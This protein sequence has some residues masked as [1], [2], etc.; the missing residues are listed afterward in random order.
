MPGLAFSHFQFPKQEPMLYIGI[1]WAHLSDTI[2]IISFTEM[3]FVLCVYL[4][5]FAHQECFMEQCRWSVDVYKLLLR[6]LIRVCR[7]R[8]LRGR[9]LLTV[10]KALWMPFSMLL[11]GWTPIRMM[12]FGLLEVCLCTAFLNSVFWQSRNVRFQPSDLLCMRREAL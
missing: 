5:W 10:G 7:G 11:H 1:V 8:G 6:W 9:C 4:F 2:C 12:L 3:R